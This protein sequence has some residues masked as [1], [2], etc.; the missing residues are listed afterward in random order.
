MINSRKLS[1]DI[2][3]LAKVLLD[4][5]QSSRG[6]ARCQSDVY[7]LA[8]NVVFVSIKARIR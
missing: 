2:G 5:W 1:K 8:Q 6:S 7:L 3:F 4:T